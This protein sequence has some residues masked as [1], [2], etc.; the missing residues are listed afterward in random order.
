LE[1]EEIFMPRRRGRERSTSRAKRKFGEVLHDTIGEALLDKGFRGINPTRIVKTLG[2]IP[3]E[4]RPVIADERIYNLGLN[5]SQNRS[6]V[7]VFTL[8]NQSRDSVTVLMSSPRADY[9]SPAMDR[10]EIYFKKEFRKGNP[11]KIARMVADRAAKEALAKHPQEYRMQIHVHAKSDFDGSRFFDDGASNIASIVRRSM[12]HNMDVL[13]FTPHNSLDLKSFARLEKVC[14]SLGITA[15]LGLELTVPLIKDHVNGPHH[16]LM[17]GSRDAAI[18]IGSNILSLRESDLKMPSY[19]RALGGNT[20]LDD[21]YKYLAPLRAEGLAAV[22]AAHGMNYNS[23]A[24]AIKAVGLLSAADVGQ[25]DFQTAKSIAKSLDFYESW[26]RS[27]SPDSMPLNNSELFNYLSGLIPKFNLGDFKGANANMLNLAFA[28]NEDKHYLGQSTFGS[29][30]HATPPL[31]HRYLVGGDYLGAGYSFFRSDRKLTAE[32]IVSKCAD[33][34]LDLSSHIYTEM[35]GG[36]LQVAQN[37]VDMP[38]RLA[39]VF[40]KLKGKVLENYIRV[41][42]ADAFGFIGKGEFGMLGKLDK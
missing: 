40:G 41:L 15:V 26:N 23:N 24:I 34:S 12:L 20:L 33:K 32:E 10:S 4:G 11:E 29:D 42:V 27:I 19:W 37:R 3:K 25:I 18:D 31:D 17:I 36:M 9:Q 6:N 7:F 14:A 21:V 13:V 35:D 16:L 30:D 8:W 2:V 28:L 5:K 38:A 22:G 1:S 39:A